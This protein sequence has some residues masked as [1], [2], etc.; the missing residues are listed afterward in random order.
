[1]NHAAVGPILVVLSVFSI[2]AGQAAAVPPRALR[3]EPYLQ[4]MSAQWTA[5]DGLPDAMV[6]RI[7]LDEAGRVWA[8]TP[9][10]WAVLTDNEWIIANPPS[11]VQVSSP[12]TED[13]PA[14]SP[15]EPVTVAVRDPLNRLWI[16]TAGGVARWTGCRWHAYHSLRWLPDDHVNR[17]TLDADGAVWVATKGGVARIYTERMTLEEKARRIHAVLRDRH[18]WRGLIRS[19]RLRH[20]GRVAAYHLPSSDN[21]GLWTSLY[22]AAESFRY[23]ATGD[24]EAKR[25]ATESLDALLFLEEISEI[26]GFIARSYMPAGQGPQHG[27]QWHRSKD[28]RWDWKSDTSSDE[29]DGHMFAWAIYYDLVDDEVRRRRIAQVARRVMDHLLDHDLYWVGPTGKPTTWGVWAPERLNHDPKWT[30]ERGLNSLEILSYLKVVHHVTGDDK[31]QRAYES[32]VR[33]HAYATN[34]IRQK[35]I[36]PPSAV[37]HSDDELAFL[38]YYALLRYEDD[39]HLR[40]IFLLSV[41]RSWQIERPERSALFNLIYGAG[42]VNDF[43]GSPQTV[44]LLKDLVTAG[45]DLELSFDLSESI[46]ALQDTPLDLVSWRVMNS[47]REDIPRASYSSRAGRLLSS[48]V[49]PSSERRLMR[50]NGDP[51]E[52]DGGGAGLEEDDGTFFLLPYWMA[53]YHQFL[54]P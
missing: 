36:Y 37:N 17:L 8:K 31:Y 3:D 18:V 15:W 10:G 21:D 16:G 34:T 22:V 39:P 44:A 43:E 50:W 46:A 49:I 25:N 23:A 19:S 28:G 47:T 5:E 26:P 29:L 53:R 14:P 30:A 48:Y 12:S 33:D 40:R 52:L 6:Q 45:A 1:M 7:W 32:L 20:P 35:I 11:T 42:T 24:D 13:L 41:E 54:V 27:G 51:Y 38:A 9:K 4:E 2:A